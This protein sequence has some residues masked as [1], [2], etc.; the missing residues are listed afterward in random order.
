[1][2]MGVGNMRN[3]ESS[4]RMDAAEIWCRFGLGLGLRLG[5]GLGYQFTPP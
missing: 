4:M 5:L 2:Y 1:M 3:T